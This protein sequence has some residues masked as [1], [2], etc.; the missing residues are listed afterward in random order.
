M[1]QPNEPRF[2]FEREFRASLLQFK[3]F[4]ITVMIQNLRDLMFDPRLAPTSNRIT[5]VS[6]L[7]IITSLWGAGIV[8][9][10]NV[11]AGKDFEDPT[12]IGF[13]LKSIDQGG[14]LGI[15]SD[16]VR[17]SSQ[18]DKGRMAESL[19]GP[20]ASMAMD[21]V[22]MLGGA[23]SAAIDGDY[24][25]IGKSII[26]ILRSETPGRTF[27]TKLA[28][29]RL[30]FDKMEDMIRPDSYKDWRRYQR[31]LKKRTGQEFWW[32]QGETTPE[33]FPGVA[34]QP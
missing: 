14:S 8:Q 12:T 32:K 34:R 5:D 23:G 10:K 30:I 11:V 1:N 22:I 3:S 26:N 13:F 7:V 29:E 2:S 21:V 28:I 9:L 15:L 18:N 16:G 27:Y 20:S 24:P 33:R 25:K 17:L 6:N 31:S 4:P 19:L